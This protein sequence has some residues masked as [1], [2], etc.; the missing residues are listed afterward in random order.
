MLVSWFCNYNES[1]L[2]KIVCGVFVKQTDSRKHTF[3]DCQKH[4]WE[5]P[6]YRLRGPLNRTHFLYKERVRHGDPLRMVLG[7]A[8]FDLAYGPPLHNDG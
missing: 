3:Y 7:T 4:R 2:S 5:S 8:C 1:I 6:T